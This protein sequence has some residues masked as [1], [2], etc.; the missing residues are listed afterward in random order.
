[1]KHGKPFRYGILFYGL[2]VAF[3]FV[4]CGGEDAEDPWEE[5]RSSIRLPQVGYFMLGAGSFHSDSDGG[6]YYI[7]KWPSYGLLGSYIQQGSDEVDLFAPVQLPDGARI[8]KVTHYFNDSTSD[9]FVLAELVRSEPGSYDDRC[10]IIFFG[11][12]DACWACGS[13]G[14]GWAG[15]CW[16]GGG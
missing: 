14:G 16:V 7:D 12:S 9:G 11:F 5:I 13:V 10:K 4:G 15:C 1:M 2:V 8:R 6:Y 3:L